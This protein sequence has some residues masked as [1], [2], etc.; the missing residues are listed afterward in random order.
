MIMFRGS[1]AIQQFGALYVV[2][3]TDHP[4]AK[5]MQAPLRAMPGTVS[6][7][8]LTTTIVSGPFTGYLKRFWLPSRLVILVFSW[9]SDVIKSY[10][11]RNDNCHLQGTYFACSCFFENFYIF[12]LEHVP[13]SRSLTKSLFKFFSYGNDIC[14]NYYFITST[15]F[16]LVNY[17]PTSMSRRVCRN[18][19]VFFLPFL[20][21]D[22]SE[23]T[24]GGLMHLQ[25]RELREPIW[26]WVF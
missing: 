23:T 21:L 19:S 14:P 5:L 4:F 1:G 10:L 15:V 26:D 8:G 12:Y 13:F 7:I 20:Y 16:S 11:D 17:W 2:S 25:K 24:S 3:S 6:T 18:K 22:R 9:L